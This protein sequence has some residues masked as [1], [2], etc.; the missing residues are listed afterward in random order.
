[1]PPRKR[2]ADTESAA[3]VAKRR[4][5]RQ[6][7][8][9]TVA[10]PEPAAAPKKNAKVGGAAASAKGRGSGKKAPRSKV[11]DDEEEEDKVPAREEHVEKKKK[12]KKK[13]AVAVEESGDADG[14]KKKKG[15]DKM[16]KEKKGKTADDGGTD[17][18]KKATGGG[19]GFENGI[20]VRFSIDDLRARDKPEPWDGIRNYVARNNM[21]A[22]NAGDKAFFYHSN[23]KEPGI[24]GIMEIVKEYSEDKGA[25]RPGTPYYDATATKE[26]N[27]WGLVHVQ[28]VKKFA[29]PLTLKELREMGEAGSP[30][31]ACRC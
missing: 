1:M 10:A 29:V 6:A 26:K 18:G 17:G 7:Q 31:R 30:W 20:D 21:K 12:E 27:R 23:C 13:V 28:F 25:R 14:A 2:Q 24:A 11:E 9:Q 4:S 3:P 22:M 5:A 15:G 19:R 16:T 8:Q